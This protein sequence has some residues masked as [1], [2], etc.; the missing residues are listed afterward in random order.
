MYH[1]YTSSKSLAGRSS[2]DVEGSSSGSDAGNVAG[3]MTLSPA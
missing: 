3:M 2:T 1:H